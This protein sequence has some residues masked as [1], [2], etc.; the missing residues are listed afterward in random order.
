MQLE[1]GLPQG[2][3]I[4]PS[5]FSIYTL[6]LGE[7]L[8]K[9]DLQYHCYAD[10]T[11]IYESVEPVQA[12]VDAAITKIERCIDE[13][14][15]WMSDNYLKL[16]DDKTEFIVLGSN[17]QIN[18][19]NIPHIRVGN[20]NIV[21]SA[22][23]RNLGIM[24]DS[25]LTMESHINAI[26][27]AAYMSIR[28]IGRIRTHLNKET[29]EMIVHAFITSKIDIGNALLSGIPKA[30]IKR[31]QRIQNIAARITTYT[32]TKVHITPV[33]KEL[34]WLPV[35]YR[36]QY[37]VALYVYKALN[38]IAPAYIAAMVNLYMPSR[39]SLRSSSKKLIHQKAA[40]T[41]WGD[42]SFSVAA[43]KLW[44]TLPG[45]VKYAN[46]IDS[47]KKNLKTFLFKTAY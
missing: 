15:A 42:R 23:V 26:S 9:H 37:K 5:S 29:T 24:M 44:N 14:R 46:S 11:Q 39:K 19:V 25:G 38:G 16:N 47:F 30:Q 40:K 43:A 7:I 33:L 31:L 28:N 18:K 20:A 21:P 1:Y 4:G 27:K 17:Y 2:S 6:P 10:D 8:R 12:K 35:E 32:N 13:I 22:A 36:V 45:S 3:V 41:Q 34:H